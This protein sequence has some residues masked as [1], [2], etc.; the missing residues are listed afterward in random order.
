MKR[1]IELFLVACL[2]GGLVAWFSYSRNNNDNIEDNIAMQVPIQHVSYIPET[3][4][5][6]I[7]SAKTSVDQ[8]V[9]VMSSGSQTIMYNSP[10]DFM[11]GG[12]MQQEIPTMSS[13]SGVIISTDGY[14]VTNNHV[15]SNANDIE[16]I[17]NNKKSYKAKVIGTDEAIDLALIKIEGEE[18][19]KFSAM[20]YGNSDLIEIGEW[21][22]AIGNPF[23]LNSTVTAGIVSAKARSLGMSSK[24]SLEAFIQTDA[25]VNPGNSG[26]ALINTKGELIGINTA[27]ASR[28]GSYVGYSFAI[29]VNIVKKV[30]YDLMEYGEVQRALLGVSIYEINA[31]TAKELNIKN[32]QGVFVNAVSENGAASDAGVEIGDVITHINNVPIQNSSQLYEQIGTHRPG[33]KIQVSLIRNEKTKVLDLI[34]KNQNNQTTM[35]KVENIDLLGAKFKVMSKGDLLKLKA[36]NGLQITELNPGQLRMKGVKVGFV[37]TKVNQEKVY[38]VADLK[39]IINKSAGGVLIEGVY[40]NGKKAY[41][42]IGIE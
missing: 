7:N 10:F 5:N 36:S 2:S 12:G 27:I 33:D 34:L 29:P 13:G 20:P 35:K 37:V 17:L 24:T 39:R 25:A 1:I 32:L 30:V 31:K 42:A 21:V 38:T 15:I 23:N 6:F 8:V 4:V 16:I 40:P 19:E 11:F 14:I 22:L 41:Y 3:S 9:H 26:G 28:T 18:G